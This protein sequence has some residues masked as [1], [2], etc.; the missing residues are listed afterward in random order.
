MG[1]TREW[2]IRVQAGNPEAPSTFRGEFMQGTDHRWTGGQV[3]R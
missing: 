1:L 3:D 2:E